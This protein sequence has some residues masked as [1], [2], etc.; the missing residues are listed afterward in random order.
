LVTNRKL[1][2]DRLLEI[3]REAVAGGVDAVHLRES[4]LPARELLALAKEVRAITREAGARFIVNHSLDVAL[5]AE[6]D[7]V[8]LGWRSLPAREARRAAPA[9]FLIGVSTHSEG[10]AAHAASEPIDYLFL[11][12]IFRTPSKEGL[13]EPLG[14]IALR[15]ARRNVKVPV[16]A[17]GGITPENA[18]SAITAGAGGIAVISSIMTAPSPRDAA[19]R[20]KEA[21]G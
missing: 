3:V 21:L 19:K 12:P 17:I 2:E 15:A 18:R 20:L 7:G 8:H 9:P 6:A 5:A 11:G 1:A 14:L 10:A 4:D 13:V 16:I